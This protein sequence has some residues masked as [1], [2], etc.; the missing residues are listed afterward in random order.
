MLR[1]SASPSPRPPC[2]RSAV[3]RA[4][5][6]RSNTWGSRAGSMPM[7]LSVTLST[8]R[9]SLVSA[10]SAIR[11]PG[12]VYLAALCSRLE[13]TWTRR[14]LSPSTSASGVRTST[15]SWC[16]F[17]ATRGST[18]S[19]ALWTTEPISTRCRSIATSPRVTRET[20]SRSWIRDFMWSTWR[21]MISL[22]RLTTASVPPESLSM[23][24]AAMIGASGL[25]SSWASMA[26]NSSFAWFWFSAARRAS[27]SL[28]SSCSRS[29]SSCCLA[30]FSASSLTPAS[31]MARCST[32]ASI[33]PDGT[34]TG[35][36][37]TSSDFAAA[38][39]RSNEPVS[40]RANRSTPTTAPARPIA[41]ASA[42]MRV[43][44]RAGLL[45]SPTGAAI[46]TVQLARVARVN[47]L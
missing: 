19:T 47:V 6:K 38:S 34:T 36:F 2:E 5:L 33:T 12:G 40:R 45:I 4:C 37:P 11:P 3:R 22:V 16:R 21:T 24:A 14:F 29:R 7:P 26:R 32:S 18:C 31:C 44:V 17:D 23:W 42:A 28:S 41:S 43:A 20:S 10:A 1:T 9:R 46:D 39:V 15:S 30:W 8:S 13:S 25:R 35:I 27:R